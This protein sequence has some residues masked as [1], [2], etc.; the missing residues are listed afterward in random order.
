M[1]KVPVP[2]FW[3]AN[4]NLVAVS[5]AKKW[6]HRIIIGI[7]LFAVVSAGLWA[8]TGGLEFLLTRWYEISN[9]KSI[10]ISKP[11]EGPEMV[12]I[13]PGK[14]IEGNNTGHSITLKKPFAIGRC[15]VTFDDYR[16]F[17]KATGET[18]PNSEGWGQGRRPV[19]NV[20]WQ[21]AVDYAR[22]LSDAT[23]KS[24]RLPTET[25]WNYAARAGTKTNYWWG[26]EIGSNKANCDGCGSL[27]DSRMTAPVGSFV[28]NGFGLFDTSGNVWEWVQDCWHDDY[29]DAPTDGSA[30]LDKDGADCGRRVIRGGSWSNFPRYLRSAT[31]DGGAAGDRGDGVGFRLAQDLN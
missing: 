26:D 7:F 19:I 31:R 4:T 27:W 10:C 23:G 18:L 9:K 14:S 16:A 12:V 3:V 11:G 15:E 1:S 20:S 21:D 5:V 30:W 22:W 28:P 29:N 13:T 2:L 8:V 17:V 25:E 24:Y 6:R